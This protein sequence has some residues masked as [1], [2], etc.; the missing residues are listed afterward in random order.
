M[1]QD[2][3]VSNEESKPVEPKEEFVSRKA[4]EETQ[5]DMHKYKARA[6]AESAAKAEYEAQLKAIEEDRLVEA[7][8]FKELYE[9]TKAEAETFKVQAEQEKSNYMTSV[10]KQ[11]LKQEL[12]GNIK[13]VYLS[14]AN[15]TG[16]EINPETGTI[17]TDSL[18]EVANQFRN[19]HGVLIQKAQGGNPTALPGNEINSA[20]KSLSEM[21][22]EERQILLKTMK[23]KI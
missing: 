14:H 5:R 16:I 6:K 20:P 15:I 17:D 7:Q 12:G 23:T 1:S 10:K 18:L 4:Y 22:I 13:D 19:D 8:Q 11:A 9:K 3:V 2:N 21:S